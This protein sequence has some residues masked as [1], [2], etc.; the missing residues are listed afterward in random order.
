MPLPKSNT[1]RQNVSELMK[2]P[3]SQARKKAIIT[4]SK[5]NNISRSDAQFKQALAIARNI[6]RK[7]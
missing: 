5:R 3:Q 4:I 1:I 7:P 6:S 2:P